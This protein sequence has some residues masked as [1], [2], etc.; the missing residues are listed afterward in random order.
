MTLQQACI[1]I[2]PIGPCPAT[3]YFSSEARQSRTCLSRVSHG[4]NHRTVGRSPLSA[5]ISRTSRYVD[6]QQAY[7]QVKLELVPSSSISPSPRLHTYPDLDIHIPGQHVDS[8]IPYL[9][10]NPL[11]NPLTF[12]PTSNRRSV[13]LP[14]VRKHGQC[15]RFE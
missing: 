3:G 6:Y 14:P 10:V 11:A 1:S 8:A 5:H 15:Q 7:G 9:R 4:S 2:S 13:L 12:Q